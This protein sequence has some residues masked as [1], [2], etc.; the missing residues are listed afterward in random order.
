MP[1]RWVVLGFVLARVAVSWA[2]VVWP[3]PAPEPA[4]AHAGEPARAP[5][6]PP[7][8]AAPTEPAPQR[9]LEPLQATT[10]EPVPSTAAP[11]PSAPRATDEEPPLFEHDTGP[12]AEYRER[13]AS[14][15]RDSAA[16]DAEAL[17]RDAFKPSDSP[18]PLFRSVLCRS[19][20][21]K[22]ELR[23]RG[24]QLGAYVA[25]MARITQNFDS[26][27]A[28]TRTAQRD[29]E[30]SLEVYAKRLAPAQ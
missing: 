12:V 6:S 29:G 19:S 5:D 10:D 26:V 17:I 9:A 20:V 16:T 25:A 14:E 4:S 22:L 15:P 28:V 30:V 8:A 11:P 2:L 18:S 27:L 7:L 1:Q 13:F 24:D 3:T 21:C 23:M